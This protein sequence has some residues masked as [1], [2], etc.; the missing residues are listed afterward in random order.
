MIESE[1]NSERPLR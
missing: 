1:R